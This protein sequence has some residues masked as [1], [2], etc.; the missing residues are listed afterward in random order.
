MLSKLYYALPVQLF[1]LNLKRNRVILMLWLLLFL[2]VTGHFAHAYGVPYLMLDPEY[3]GKVDFWS[4]FILG[5]SFGI[6]SM[7]YHITIYILES[8][9][10]R[11][12]MMRND[13][14]SI[15]VLNNSLFPLLFIVVFVWEFVRFQTIQGE[16]SLIE[17]VRELTG[18]LLG[19]HLTL[20]FTL[21]YFKLTG[22]AIFQRFTQNL[23]A[24]MRL[25]K[26]SRARSIQQIKMIKRKNYHCDYYLDYPVRFRKVDN[27]M[28]YDKT[29]TNK[30]I[31][32]N[33]LNAF[34]LQFTGF[35]LIL[36]FGYFRENKIFQIP[37]GASIFILI[38]MLTMLIG[39]VQF[40]L[41]GWWLLTVLL[42]FLLFN[43]LIK[44]GLID[45]NCQAFGLNYS[46][47]KAPYSLE[48]LSALTKD[49][50]L[51]ADKWQT[52]LALERWK[53]KQS[54]KKPK[55]ML[56]CTSGGGQR[57]A[58]WTMRALQV[59]DSLLQGTMLSHATVITG[60]S[61]GLIGA[62]YFREL[63]LRKSLGM[64][65][66]PTDPKYLDNISK[67]ILNPV[68]FS[69]IVNDIFLRFE[70]FKYGNYTYTKD[71]GF[72]FEK[73]L[74]QN[75]E[76][77]MY[78]KFMDYHVHESNA[79]IPIL[80]LTPTIVNDGRKL[81][82]SSMPM[83]YMTTARPET[84][85]K[86]QTKIKGIEFMRMFEDQDAKNLSFLSGLRLSA[87][88]P[89]ITPNVN[90]PSYPSMEI[91][92][93]GISDNYGITEAVRFCHSFKEWI[94]ENTSG[95]VFVCIRDSPKILP[96]DKK[97]TTTL[98]DKIV[99]PIG[100][101]YSTWDW[102][103]DNTND[104]NLEYATSFLDTVHVVELQYLSLPKGWES[105]NLTQKQLDEAKLKAYNQRASLNWHLTKKEKESLKRSIY[106]EVNRKNLEKLRR[107]FQ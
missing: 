9:R 54:S 88:F 104:N 51:K 107:L 98:I 15:F 33:H 80:L 106:E 50:I 29:L 87:T 23:S 13:P 27:F 65:I 89:Y 85:Q 101:L 103:Q 77:M 58:V 86:F 56:I 66:E 46:S 14:F 60:A 91:M 37:A 22:H 76:N 35:V 38:A 17:I 25:Q 8:D 94:N 83:S 81:M 44:I 19:Y 1:L 105:D 70:K 16:Q 6:F 41:K 82:I 93:A 84:K 52:Q 26:I 71:R 75:T 28:P 72:A 55:M 39:A 4:L 47:H 30:L 78:K 92:D 31:D 102:L 63:Y 48:R 73:Q 10:F 57:A 62:S 34:L 53:A 95:V 7:A 79:T 64:D 96:I 18:F 3:L 61:G 42:L 100:T 67:D 74:N 11:F 97:N 90:L 2:I 5:F 43:S 21:L 36:V 24:T 59:T 99:N 69:L 20:F 40:W 32:Q 68:V 49:S 45:P 12:I